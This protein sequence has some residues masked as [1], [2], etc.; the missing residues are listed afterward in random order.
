MNTTQP[1]PGS[2]YWNSVGV[3]IF[4]DYSGQTCWYWGIKANGD[5][6]LNGYY[7]NILNALRAPS[8]DPRTQ[9]VNLAVAVGSTPWGTGNFSSSC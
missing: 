3:Q 5:T 8:S 2:T 1:E 4:R 7:T 6:L 9:C